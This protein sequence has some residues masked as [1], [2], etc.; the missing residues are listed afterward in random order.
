MKQRDFEN[1]LFSK[2]IRPDREEC[3]GSYDPKQ[4]KNEVLLL[5]EVL[6]PNPQ[7]SSTCR[8]HQYETGE[9]RNSSTCRVHQNETGE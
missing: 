2:L 7:D 9:E 5:N 6:R 3:F 1:S 4:E 8:V